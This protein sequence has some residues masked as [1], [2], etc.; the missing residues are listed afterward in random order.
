VTVRFAT[1]VA[2][3]ASI[4]AG[5]IHLGLGPEHLDELGWLGWGFH[6]AGAAQIGWAVAA[7]CFLVLRD[8]GLAGSRAAGSFARRI[9][10]PA[11]AGIAINVAILG[12]WVVSRTVGLP[13]GETPW[14]AEPIARAD[15]ITALL[16]TAVVAGLLVARREHR[17]HRAGSATRARTAVAVAFVAIV[18]ATGVGLA[19]DDLHAAGHQDANASG[20]GIVGQHEHEAGPEPL[21]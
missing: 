20:P 13:A 3:A 4:G 2:V 6:V 16:E 5:V 12:A 8:G 11:L 10:R 17:E 14:V 9:R 1:A 7:A 18:L 15:S 19:P 21:R